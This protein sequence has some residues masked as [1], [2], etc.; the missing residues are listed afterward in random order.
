[1]ESVLPGTDKILPKLLMRYSC[2]FFEQHNAQIQHA[3]CCAWPSIDPAA[4]LRPRVEC[5]LPDEKGGVL[6]FSKASGSSVS[7]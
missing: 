3:G 2:L 5:C 4:F 7:G 6:Q 1:M